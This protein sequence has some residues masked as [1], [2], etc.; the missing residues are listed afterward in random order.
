ML[1]E[2]VTEAKLIGSKFDDDFKPHYRPITK[3]PVDK[4][5]VFKP[6]GLKSIAGDYWMVGD[7]HNGELARVWSL[8]DA[9]LICKAVNKYLSE[10][11]I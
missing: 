2:T 11:G 7:K 5:Q 3:K 8:T 10:I 4:W 6:T 9:R 1:G